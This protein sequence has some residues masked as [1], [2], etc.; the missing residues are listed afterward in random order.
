[1]PNLAPCSFC[2]TAADPESVVRR[3]NQQLAEYQQMRRWLVWPDQDFP[4]TPTQKPKIA[5]IQQAV[6]QHFASGDD[7]AGAPQ[8]ALADLIAAS[9]D[10]TSARLPPMPSWKAT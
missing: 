9:P 4:R 1:M 7:G 5:D 8:G 6:Q 2:A 10:A 3:A